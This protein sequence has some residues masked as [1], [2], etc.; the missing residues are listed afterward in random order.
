[1]QIENNKKY[2]YI[3]FK[4]KEKSNSPDFQSHLCRE[5]DVFNSCNKYECL[6]AEV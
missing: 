2:I 1:M 4:P 5:L 3:Y 6:S